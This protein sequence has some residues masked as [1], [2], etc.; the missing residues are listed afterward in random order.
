MA[1]RLLDR[2]RNAIALGKVEYWGHRPAN[3]K[4][5]TFDLAMLVMAD[6]LTSVV[7]KLRQSKNG[8]HGLDG[9]DYV[10]SG[11]VTLKGP[12]TRE[13]YFKLFF[14]KEDD[15]EAEQGIEV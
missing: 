14:W 5:S 15:P 6:S 12:K 9:E 3:L 2:I 13:L 1:T 8:K 4:R 10:Y 11:K 7:K